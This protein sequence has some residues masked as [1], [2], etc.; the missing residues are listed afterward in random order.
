MIQS[1]VAVL[2]LFIVPCIV[3]A[4]IFS[5]TCI[6]ELKDAL[7]LQQTVCSSLERDFYAYQVWLGHG[8]TKAYF[9]QRHFTVLSNKERERLI[10]VFDIVKY[11]GKI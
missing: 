4:F 10:K 1:I 9:E 8:F 11:E 3:I 6:K 7:R 5:F 2:V